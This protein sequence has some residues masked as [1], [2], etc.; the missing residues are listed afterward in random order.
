MFSKRAFKV[1]TFLLVAA[2]ALGLLPAVQR[3]Q[4]QSFSATLSPKAGLV[5]HLAAGKTEWQTITGTT[6]INEGDQIRTG[7]NGQAVLTIVT[8]TEI[9]I[10]PVSIVQLDELA[11]TEA[12]G[13]SALTF[14]LYQFVGATHIKVD[15]KVNPQDRV[16]V[17]LPLSGSTVRGTRFYN[18]TMPKMNSLIMGDEG[19]VD[20]SGLDG[21]TYLVTPPEAYYTFVNLPPVLPDVC[22]PE[23]IQRNADDLYLTEIRS[24]GAGVTGLRDHLRGEVTRNV[25][26]EIRSLLKKELGLPEVDIRSLTMEE[27]EK[28]LQELLAAIDSFDAQGDDLATFLERYREYWIGYWELGLSQ[29]IVDATC[30]NNI[31]DAGETAETC[32]NDF[33]FKPYC[34]NNLCETDRFNPGVLGESQINCP[35]DC[36]IGNGLDASCARVTDNTLVNPPQPPTGGGG[37]PS[38]VGFGN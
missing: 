4:A 29:P 34:G 19:T 16:Q 35:E 33:N 7:W 3:S 31:E 20:V 5:Q 12:S 17:I 27:D 18:F 6:L 21:R 1:L 36:R 28:D 13:V 26:P 30:G 32:P 2:V 22:S 11:L 24:G 9:D 15:Q 8:G 14:N 37:Q 10:Y 23:F 25:N 38:G